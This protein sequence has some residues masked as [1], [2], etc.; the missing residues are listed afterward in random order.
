M[1]VNDRRGNAV[2]YIAARPGPMPRECAAASVDE[3]GKD[4]SGVILLHDGL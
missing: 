4:V 3:F 2:E 1:N